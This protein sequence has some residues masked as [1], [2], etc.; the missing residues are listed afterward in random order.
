M[1]TVVR[2]GRP[3]VPLE[4]EG[5]SGSPVTAEG[6]RRPVSGRS[7]ETWSV[8]KSPPRGPVDVVVVDTTTFTSKRRGWSLGDLIFEVEC[9]G[10]PRRLR[11]TSRD[12]SY[13]EG[14]WDRL[15]E[16]RKVRNE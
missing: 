10:G 14:L 1:S 11:G 3:N 12:G 15:T 16:G 4:N 8:T 6:T 13:K 2:C 5:R 7:P 9:T